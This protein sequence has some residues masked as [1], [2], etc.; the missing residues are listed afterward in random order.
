MYMKE[1]LEE[2]EFSASITHAPARALQLFMARSRPQSS[3]NR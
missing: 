3:K 2:Q 1:L